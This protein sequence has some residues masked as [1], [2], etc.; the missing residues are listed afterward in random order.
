VVLDRTGFVFKVLFGLDVSDRAALGVAKM[1]LIDEA[2]MM[3]GGV[4]VGAQ[5]RESWRARAREL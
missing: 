1:P 5:L 2:R 4:E 3:F